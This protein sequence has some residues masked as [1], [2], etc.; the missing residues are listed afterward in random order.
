MPENL[1]KE[2]NIKNANFSRCFLQNSK[3]R[4]TFIF[5][6]ARIIDRE[7]KKP[8]TTPIMHSF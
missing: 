8:C 2:Y 6:Y 4:L 5:L 7:N 1:T 3:K